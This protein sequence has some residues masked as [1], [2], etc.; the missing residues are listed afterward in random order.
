[1]LTLTYPGWLHPFEQQRRWAWDVVPNPSLVRAAE[2]IRDWRASG[3]LPPE[4]R[5]LNL[6]P[7]FASYLAWY[8]PGEKAYFDYRLGFHANEAGE[9]AALRR[10]LSTADARKRK[11]DPFD[12]NDFLTRYGITFAVYAP[13]RPDTTRVMLASLW[14][15]DDIGSNPDWVLWDVQGRA[16]TF[17]WTRQRTIPTAAF[18]RLRFDPLRLAYAD[19]QPLRLPSKDD[20]HPPPTTAADIWERF[21]VPPP[22]PPVDAEE[23]KVLQAYRTTLLE[24]ATYR[25]QVALVDIRAAAARFRTPALDLWTGIQANPQIGLIP[26]VFPAEATA[27]A[28]LAV[29]AAR[30]AVLDSPNHP[31]G[32]YFLGTAYADIGFTSAGDLKD[33]VSTVSLA[34]ARARIPDDPTQFRPAFDVADLA[35]NLFIAHDRGAVPPRLD[36]AVD[37]L[38]LLI[39]Y[40]RQ[41]VQDREAALTTL[42]ADSRESAEAEL[43]SRRRFLGLVEKD[44]QN[45]E[46]ILQRNLEKYLIG[47][48]D[49]SSAVE[50]AAVARRFGLVREAITELRKAHEQFQKQL[51]D[52]PDQEFPPAEFAGHLAVHAEL[53]EQL[54]YEGK[55]EEAAQILDTV[56]TPVVMRVMDSPQVRAEYFRVRQ[57]AMSLLF[58]GSKTVPSSPYDA[59]PAGHFRNLR[60]AMSTILGDFERAKEVQ[61]QEAQ[62]VRQQLTEFM[63]KNF[64]TGEIPKLAD[65][66]D[67]SSLQREMAFKPVLAAVTFARMRQLGKVYDVRTLS[68]VRAEGQLSIALTYLEWG[69]VPRAVHHLKQAE[70]APGWTEPIRAQKLSRDLLKAIERAGPARGTSP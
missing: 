69:D 63:A 47:A 19:A 49:R 34:R 6:Q 43:D 56:D 4:A 31:D 7:D 23:S 26:T 24:R 58:Q 67:P 9:Y 48:A 44:L 42:P 22:T 18:D 55:V 57:R 51:Q 8:A 2:K 37:V 21:L 46:P 17:G 50:R 16:V 33:V 36:L 70:D 25:H 10:Y 28:T 53:I 12:L 68:A 3:A 38:K 13:A 54:W 52:K 40:L 14:S 66:P 32:Y 39:T 5:V 20:L 11:Q 15:G 1:M 45:K 61:V 29:R 60:R 41:D 35:R 59:D 64:P 62:Q 30:Q 65:L 27:V